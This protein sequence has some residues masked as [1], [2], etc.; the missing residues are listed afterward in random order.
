M[1]TITQHKQNSIDTILNLPGFHLLNESLL[2]QRWDNHIHWLNSWSAGL[3]GSILP[4]KKSLS[5]L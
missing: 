2:E 3:P 4:R 5:K 1:N